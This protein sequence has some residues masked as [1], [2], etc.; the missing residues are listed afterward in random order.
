LADPGAPEAVQVAGIAAP[1]VWVSRAQPGAER[2]ALALKALGFEPLVEP[3]I[4]TVP[5]DV[6]PPALGDYAALA[7]T[8]A[9][10]VSAF[11]NC[12]CDR[13]VLVYAVGAATAKAALEA[14]WTD[15]LSA[16]GDVEALARLI[17]LRPPV[18]AV[19]HPGAEDLAG[20][21]CGL[22]LD[23]GLEA[24]RLALYR[25]QSIPTPSPLLKSALSQ[26]RIVAVL[27]HSPSAGKALVEMALS[28]AERAGLTVAALSQ[29][30]TQPLATDRFRD[31]IISPVPS[32]EALLKLLVE[33]QV[34]LGMAS[35]PAGLKTV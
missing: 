18:G 7:F 13:S 29:A 28:D 11:A 2:T 33:K 9:A 20:D 32:E 34:S 30:C 17:L 12:V 15:V 19:L 25:T 21:L 10:A 1:L 14:G 22:L 6:D 23:G 16:D 27:L 35:P 31:I 5:L 26:G 24:A 8:S 3:L 4:R